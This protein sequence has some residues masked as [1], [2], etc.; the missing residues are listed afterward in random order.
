MCVD[1]NRVEFREPALRAVTIRAVI[2]ARRVE[3]VRARRCSTGDIC[4][5]GDML[6]EFRV[7]SARRELEL[8]CE[9]VE[10]ALEANLQSR[11]RDSGAR[12]CFESDLGFL[13]SQ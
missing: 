11:V 7:R 9:H 13:H 4:F 2:D 3:E 1:A 10:G 5:F 12:D 8:L 6:F